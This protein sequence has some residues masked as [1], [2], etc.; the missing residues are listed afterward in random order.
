[1]TMVGL[2]PLILLKPSADLGMANETRSLRTNGGF[3]VVLGHLIGAALVTTGL[4]Y[5]VVLWDAL[6][7][8]RPISDD[9]GRAVSTLNTTT[10][11]M[12]S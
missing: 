11:P 12:D 10:L 8:R 3:L 6:F 4:F 5:F 9:T 7:C 2:S 1:M